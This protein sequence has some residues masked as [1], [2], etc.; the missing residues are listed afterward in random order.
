[1]AG[2]TARP[3]VELW[4]QATALDSSF[5]LAYAELGNAAYT[6]NNRPVGDAHFERALSLLDR[7]TTREA[8]Q[9]RAAVEGWRGN[10]DKAIELYHAQLAEYPND[11]TAWGRIGYEYMRLSRPADAITALR[12]QI[13]RDSTNPADHINLASAFKQAGSTPKR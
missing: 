4:R 11:P 5:A 6:S 1:M 2:W 9:I 12:T 7:L 3:A 8:L 10:R 13:A